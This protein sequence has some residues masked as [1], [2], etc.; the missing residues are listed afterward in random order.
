M[1]ANRIL[2]RAGGRCPLCRRRHGDADGAQRASG[3]R[4]RSRRL[5][6]GHHLHA[7]ADAWR[8]AATAS[9]GRAAAPE[10]D[11]HA[12]GARDDVPLWRRGGRR[13]D[14]AIEWRGCAVRAAP[15]LARQHACGC[16]AGSRRSGAARPHACRPD[17]PTATDAS[18]ARRFWMPK[19]T[20]MAIRSDL[21]VGAD[22]IGSSVARLAGAETVREARNATAVMFG[23]FPGIDLTRLPLV[24]SA[25]CRRRRHSDQSRAAL[26][27][28]CDAP[29][30]LRN[31]PW[32][33]DRSAA[34]GAILHEADPALAAPG[35]RLRA[36]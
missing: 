27:L 25:G 34:F 30:R 9:L 23:Y 1:L 20:P 13:R 28:R 19:A 12:G 17:P 29:G 7:C 4:H 5:R 32:R 35:C 18:A 36:G 3:T 2:R 8:C 11:G 14:P 16:R 33:D 31:G 10:G 26:H 6:H 24:V 22:G 21:V 15:D